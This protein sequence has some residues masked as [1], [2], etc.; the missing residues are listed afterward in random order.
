[1]GTTN[2]G[3]QTH[4]YDYY[5]EGTAKGFNQLLYKG[6]PSGIYDGFT[7]SRV[8]NTTVQISTG[9]CYI[10]DSTN[11]LLIRVSTSTTYNLGS[12]PTDGSKDLIVFRFDWSN[13]ENNYMDMLNIAT[14]DID[15]DDIIVGKLVHSAGTL[16]TQF[17]YSG[18]DVISFDGNFE[19]I[20]GD[21]DYNDLTKAGYY[22]HD[23]SNTI[24]NNPASTNP[25]FV[26]VFDYN[27]STIVVQEVTDLTNDVMYYRVYNSSWGSWQTISLGASDTW[28]EVGDVGEP[29]FENSWSNWGASDRSLRFK[30]M[31]DNTVKIEGTLS[32]RSASNT[33]VFTLPAGYRPII[34]Y[35]F[36]A[37]QLLTGNGSDSI[38]GRI[39]TDGSVDL[40][41]YSTSGSDFWI[42]I[43]V[44]FSLD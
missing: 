15:S 43:M 29:A 24:A 6:L 23:G 21:L 31:S 37:I 5:Q 32:A 39:G 40:Y 42:P 34:T 36:P 13:T 33:T 10:K 44:E 27:D 3:N 30:L 19:S 41:D 25:V 4:T 20:I 16:Q 26:K 11:N 35:Q 22:Y 8:D 12:I 1:M 17:D 7:L 28:H 9:I 14:A 18:R 2:Y 38:A